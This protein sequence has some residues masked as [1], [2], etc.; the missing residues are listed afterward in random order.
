MIK[1]GKAIIYRSDDKSESFYSLLS[2][3]HVSLKDKIRALRV[4]NE[5]SSKVLEDH[6]QLLKEE[7]NQKVAELTGKA[8]S[9]YDRIGL[10]MLALSSQSIDI[11]NVP[12]E[13]N[14]VAKLMEEE[15]EM[16]NHREHVRRSSKEM[17][18]VYLIIIFE[19]FLNN[20]LS[21]LFRKRPEILKSSQKNITFEEV[22]QYA[23]L[24]ELLKG[25]SKKEAQSKIN[26]DIDELGKY[27]HKMFKLNLEQRRDWNQFKEFFYRRHVIVHNYGYPDSIYIAKTK[28]K[29]QGDEWLEI[30]NEYLE[31]GFSI[32]E[33]Y[34][35]QIA[36][37]FDRK[38]S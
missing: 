11:D 3:Y 25:I 14:R 37:F 1:Y 9:E 33:K 2:F 13:H 29:G 20:L 5:L 19:E 10:E 35:N 16:Y 4:I 21:T 32:F 36:T 28:Y 6:L 31:K 17:I 24:H 7:T 26:L 23:D 34:S 27:L 15:T 18:L 8:R 12:I 22:V 30:S 38:Y